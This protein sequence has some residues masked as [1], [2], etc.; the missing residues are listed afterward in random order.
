[1]PKVHRK[2][3]KGKG[4]L[5][6][7]WGKQRL[8]LAGTSQRTNAPLEE[9]GQ[10]KQD[11]EQDRRKGG[12]V[13]AVSVLPHARPALPGQAETTMGISETF[14][15]KTMRFWLAWLVG[16]LVWVTSAGVPGTTEA[17]QNSTRISDSK[18]EQ[19]GK[20]D[21]CCGRAYV[22]RKGVLLHACIACMHRTT[23]IITKSP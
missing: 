10:A 14:W 21:M 17:K 7:E 4:N 1:M 15:S 11:K 8:P 16:W 20:K 9:T 18:A 6:N 13:V 5:G 3:K 2:G 19:D 23:S 12:G 22:L